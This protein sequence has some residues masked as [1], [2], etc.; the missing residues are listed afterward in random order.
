[1]YACLYRKRDYDTSARFPL[2]LKTYYQE[3]YIDRKKEKKETK[4]KK[5]RKTERRRRRG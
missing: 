2:F 5:E 4:E 1:M 3:C